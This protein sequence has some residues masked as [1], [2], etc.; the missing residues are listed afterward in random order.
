MPTKL[1]PYQEEGVKQIEKFGGR[2]LLADSMGLGKCVTINTKILTPNGWIPIWQL[3]V[4]DIVIGGDGKPCSVVG[5]YPQGKKQIYRVWFKD[6]VYTDCGRDHLWAVNTASRK[7][8]GSGN[9]VMTTQEIIDNGVYMPAGNRQPQ[10]KWYIPI[11]LPVQFEKQELPIPPYAMGAMLGNGSFAKRVSFS[12]IDDATIQRVKQDLIQ[13]EMVSCGNGRDY[14]FNKGVNQESLFDV[15]EKLGLGYHHANSKFI[16]HIYLFSSIEDRIQLLHGLMDTDG[17]VQKASRPSSKGSVA[18]Y[19]TVSS[20]LR[21]DVI[22][23]VRSLGGM[24]TYNTKKSPKYVCNGETRTGQDA[25]NINICLPYG[26]CAFSLKRKAE[27]C[28]NIVGKYPPSRAIT[29]IE[30]LD[31]EAEMVCIAVDSPD[32][33]YVAEHFVVTHNTIQAIKYVIETD[34]YPAVVVCPASL[35]LNWQRE[36]MMHFGKRA[37]VLSGGKVETLRRDGNCV[38]IINYDILSK[39]EKAITDLRPEIIVADEVHFVKSLQAKRTKVLLRLSKMVEH[40]IAISGT[41]MTNHVTELYPIL[42]MVLG[43]HGIESRR[44]FCDRY[45]KLE[46]TRWGFRYVG[47]RRLPELHKRLVKMCMVRRL[48]DD[49][50]PDLPTYTRQTIPIEL[51]NEN[52][53]EYVQMNAA[54][55]DWYF[56]KFPEKS[57]VQSAV[58]MTKLGYMK[59]HVAYWKL[60]FVYNWIDD[61]FEESDTKLVVFALHRKVIDGI[62]NR[63][64]NHGTLRRPFVVKVDGAINM[65]DRQRAVDLFQQRP[66][67]RL[68]VGQM[69]AAGVGLTLTAA[70]NVLF[71]EC[72]F[73]P[74][75][76]AQAEKR[77]IV[78]GSPILTPNGWVP[79]ECLH[80]GDLVINC[81]GESVAV[82]DVWKKSCRVPLTTIAIKGQGSFAVTYDHRILTSVGW[83]DAHTLLPGDLVLMPKFETDVELLK[84]P[85]PDSCRISSV[86]LN[87]HGKLQSNGR[88]V[89]SK[90]SDFLEV[91]DDLLF[92]F[93]YYVGDGFCSFPM[94]QSGVVRFCGDFEKKRE[95][96][97]RCKA[98]WEHI[99]FYVGHSR[100]NRCD[101][102]KVHSAEYARF[103]EFCFGKGAKNKKLPDFLLHLTPRQSQ[104][105][106]DGL[107][108]SDGYYRKGRFSYATISSVL[109]SQVARLALNAGYK[110]CLS[111]V[112][113][114][115]KDG[116][117][118]NGSLI[119]SKHLLHLVDYTVAKTTNASKVSWVKTEHPA[120][121]EGNHDTMVYDITTDD[122]ESFVVGLSVVH[123]CIRIGQKNHVMCTYIVAQNT[124]EEHVADILQRK[125]SEFNSVMDGG[126]VHDDFNLMKELLKRIGEKTFSKLK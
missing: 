34:S 40:F 107:M 4:G 81:K 22:H 20:Q 120:K 114:T 36:F 47:S 9:L 21:D 18:Q 80:V 33:L 103:F 14:R 104:C 102:Y 93:G 122:T 77:C 125:Q 60:P 84:I 85:F 55:A 30:V 126:K 71:A 23:L 37:E 112:D 28:P 67:T 89:T 27:L 76:H 15:F 69:R 54:F 100:K 8:H 87:N 86:F 123:N 119:M 117:V 44:E 75:V 111:Q 57:Q 46:L 73:V 50:L 66:E 83:K 68:F 124:I 41:P 13:W 90:A 11:V 106:L 12:S 92:F 82:K 49:V 1:Y 5:V 17:T 61:F 78:A 62:V 70:S 88:L 109:A 32:H 56:E 38:Y 65:D 105:I 25:Y 96:L 113:N 64:A 6:G 110:P 99:G 52:R 115:V 10:A 101:E 26:I 58:I 74:A 53:R 7:Y 42:R 19:C 91:T 63:Y 98:Y 59:R 118:V 51:P 29:K 79:I 116:S 35:K 48:V 94:N 97:D 31:E 43:E 2:A 72:D 39:W 45:S 121:H 24:A 108:A 16:P 95:A 3:K